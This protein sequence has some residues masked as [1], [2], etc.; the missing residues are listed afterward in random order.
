MFGGTFDP[1]HYAHLRLAEELG[2][3]L[4]LDEVRFI[5]ARIP[6]HRAAPN[7]T[8]QHRLEMVRLSIR[9]NPRF[10]LDERELRREGPS[11]TV[12]TLS[13]L[14]RE[15]G[16]DAALTLI[17]GED[18]YVALTTWSRWESLYDLAHIAVAARPGFDLELPKLN[19]ALAGQTAVR[20]TSRAEDLRV[21]PSGRVFAPDTTEMPISATAIRQCLENGHSARYLL[22]DE[23]LA[24]IR[25]NR[26]YKESD[27]G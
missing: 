8:A 1:I 19:P 12:D 23:V 17:M 15:L 26:L 13:E 16:A 9:D 24:Y 10:R 3:R 5:P 25:A 21:S 18:S 4:A 22:P 7:V 6:P 27:A 20:L 2:E 14:L 11:Y